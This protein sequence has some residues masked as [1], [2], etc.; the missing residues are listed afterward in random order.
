MNNEKLRARAASSG[1]TLGV[2]VLHKRLD[3]P[4][5]LGGVP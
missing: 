1:Q 5:V 2:V 4:M 3:D